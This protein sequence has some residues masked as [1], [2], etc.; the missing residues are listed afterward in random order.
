MPA[1]GLEDVLAEAGVAAA[2]LFGSR[3]TGRPRPD[4]DTDV[5]VLLRPGQPTPTLLEREALAVALAAVLGA[6]EVDLVVL[7]GAPLE[8]RARVVRTGRLL[9]APDPVARVR[10]EVDTQSRWFD[11]EPAHREQT[12]AFLRRVAQHGLAGIGG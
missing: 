4:S 6:G 5:A 9:A 3:A 11:V 7:D 10:F 1:T 8:L 12:A 2:Y